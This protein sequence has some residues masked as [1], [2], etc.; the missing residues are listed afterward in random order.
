MKKVSVIVGF[1]LILFVFSSCGGSQ[2]QG[3]NLLIE[4]TEEIGANFVEM[5]INFGG[6][7]NDSFTQIR[8]IKI[9]GE[10]LK[11]EM[12]IVGEKLDKSID[13]IDEKTS[14]YIEKIVEEENYNQYTIWGMD[15]MSDPITI[16][17]TSYRDD[18]TGFEE[19]SVFIDL[20]INTKHDR[21][22]QIIEEKSEILKTNGIEAEITTCI[23]GNFP[24]K[25]SSDIINDK[26][27]MTIEKIN[28][29]I[30]EDYYDENLA[31]VSAYSPLIDR[32]IFIGNKKMN[33]NVAMRYNEYEDATYIW[34]G[35]PII[36]TGY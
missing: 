8:D 2:S 4:M 33:F 3:E 31:S 23:V 20:I 27:R 32:Y 34:I 25:L 1:I 15:E 29:K 5:D 14:G 19:T 17:I 35:T 16:I 10:K 24:G 30:I 28:G 18:E 22:H 11:D 6:K 9:V 12:G 7:L 26:I 13:V 36:A 21:M